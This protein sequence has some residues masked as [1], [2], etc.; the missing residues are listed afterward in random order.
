MASQN[1]IYFNK[2]GHYHDFTLPI[3]IIVLFLLFVLFSGQ[4]QSKVIDKIHSGAQIQ[5]QNSRTA[6][7][8]SSL[9]PI[10]QHLWSLLAEN[11]VIMTWTWLAL[12]VSLVAPFPHNDC[13]SGFRWM[14]SGSMSWK[15][16]EQGTMHK[17]WM[18][19]VHWNRKGHTTTNNNSNRLATYYA[20][21]ALVTEYTRDRETRCWWWVEGRWELKLCR[22]TSLDSQPDTVALMA[23]RQSSVYKRIDKVLI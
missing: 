11:D 10:E 16:G 8:S 19:V 6:S 23:G 4:C 1:P 17:D 15:R 12:R 20:A 14:G 13:A 18:W 5:F 9:S 22:S 2:S 7:E 3:I 21:H